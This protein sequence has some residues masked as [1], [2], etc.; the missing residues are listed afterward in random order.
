MFR[1]NNVRDPD[2]KYHGGLFGGPNR[3]RLDFLKNI[4]MMIGT[5]LGFC[6]CCLDFVNVFFQI[7]ARVQV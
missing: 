7:V 4:F 5:P 3:Y 6:D 2:P 1:Q